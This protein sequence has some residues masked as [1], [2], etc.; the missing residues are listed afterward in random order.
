MTN[1]VNIY[2]KNCHFE[3]LSK[4]HK[5]KVSKPLLSLRFQ[6]LKKYY[7]VYNLAYK[8]LAVL[9]EKAKMVR[10]YKKKFIGWPLSPGVPLGR[11]G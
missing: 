11:Y 2:D 8:L 3:K 4:N 10:R 1:T 5:R 7:P 9:H 6:L